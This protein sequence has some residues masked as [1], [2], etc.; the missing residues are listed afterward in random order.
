MP[1]RSLTLR[2]RPTAKRIPAALPRLLEAHEV[3]LIEG[4]TRPDLVD[5]LGDGASDDLAGPRRNR[6]FTTD[7]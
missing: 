5:D 6:S 4:A 2:G 3:I 7:V 1:P